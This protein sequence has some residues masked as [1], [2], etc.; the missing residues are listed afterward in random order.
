MGRDILGH[1]HPTLLD[2]PISYF[3]SAYANVPSQ[4]TTLRRMVGTRYYKQQIEAIRNQADPAEQSKR[5]KQLPAFTLAL[6]YHR[7]ERAS[8]SAQV[9]QQWPMLMGDIDA[10]DNP[11][12]DMALV[13]RDLARLPYVLLCAQSVR[14]GLWFVV[15][16]PDHQTPATLQAHFG[17]VKKLFAD[18]FGIVLDRSKG[19]NPTHLRYVS[20]DPAPYLNEAAT[21]L[22]GTYTEK[23]T[24][25]K[26]SSNQTPRYTRP[27]TQALS[28]PNLLKRVASLAEQ[29]AEGER[30]DKLLKAAKLAGGY[31]ATGNL[32][33]QD[34][35]DA[36]ETVASEWDNFTKS[37]RT[38]RDGIRYGL[39]A[40][41]E[42]TTD[43]STQSSYPVLPG[44]YVPSQPETTTPKGPLIVKT[45]AD[46]AA[47]PGSI[48]RPDEDQLER[49]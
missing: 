8:I 32:H 3:H 36:L 15:R 29:A 26:S 13:K 5:K 10:K 25:L 42:P 39:Q 37:Q 4:T 27:N 6:L 22:T 34:A 11:E 28:R 40:P 30:H 23:V 33:E 9:N 44:S 47:N 49:L 38:I 43:G 46:W 21:E 12:L 41:I 48:L 20:Y 7:R 35:I 19:G 1:H 18:L 16:L 2:V 17:Y 31:V 45:L 14:G 24:F